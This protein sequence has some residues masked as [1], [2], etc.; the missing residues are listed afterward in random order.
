MPPI[1]LT[2]PKKVSEVI[3]C[4]E[5]RLVA[6]GLHPVLQC[7]IYIEK[8]APAERNEIVLKVRQPGS[9]EWVDSRK[10]VIQSA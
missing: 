6:L 8:P 5:T 9:E 10:L 7:T 2:P 4:R 1:S 3:Y